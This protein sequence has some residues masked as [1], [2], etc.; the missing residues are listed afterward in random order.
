MDEL[1]WP[2]YPQH[3]VVLDSGVS[4]EDGA[5]FEV[6]DT[7]G[8]VYLDAIAGI[9]SAVLG[10]AHPLW[11]EAI[12][13]QLGRLASVANSYRTVP[14]QQLARRLADLFPIEDARV[15]FANS[16]T[17]ATEAAL[18]LALRA[19]GRDMIVCFERAFHGRTLG[20]ITLTA[21]PAYR[22]PYV[23][24][25]GESHE[26]RFARAEVVRLPFGD[27]AALEACFA[28]HGER[29]AGV[30]VE[31]I[32][33]EGGVW[34]A[35]AEYLVG[36]RALCDR[37]GAL[38][39]VDEIQTGTGRTGCWSAWEA[40][41]GTELRPDILWLAKALGAGY[42]IGACLTRA[43][44]AGHMGLGSHGTTFGGN[45]V[46]C[47][48]GLATLRILEEEDLLEHA[49]KQLPTLRE[50]AD[51][52]PIDEVVEI[53]GIGAMIGIQIGALD[54]GRAK[55]LGAAMRERGVLVTTPGGHTVRLLLPYAAGR[56]ELERVWSV[57]RDALAATA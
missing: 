19:T 56:T 9:G 17:E 28:Q 5:G 18:K 8:N 51:A 54:A 31:P 23:T 52:R 34:P 15:F 42:P 11:V 1:R 30:F 35:T 50:I 7:E 20:A 27:A 2:T 48:A 49:A 25:H 29:I 37:H 41:V 16:G 6:R 40:I 10:H 13:R 12:H 45:P 55:P 36:M 47:A 43:E 14:Q 21:N 53:R 4:V 57:L 39:G 33:G 26:G 46:A 44:L 3:E 24:C 38:L 32:Q 22:D